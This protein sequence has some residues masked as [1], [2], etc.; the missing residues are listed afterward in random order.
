[1]SLSDYFGSMFGGGDPSNA[2][3][4]YSAP[5]EQPKW[6]QIL[7]TL[8]AT[9]QDTGAGINGQPGTAVAGL[10][11]HRKTLADNANYQKMLQGMMGQQFNPISSTPMVTPDNPAGSQSRQDNYNAPMEQFTGPLGAALGQKQAS[12]MFPLLQGMDPQSG[13]KAMAAMATADDPSYGT[14]PKYDAQGNAYVLDKGGNVKMLS[15][16]K[17]P[18]AMEVGPDGTAYDKSA[19]GPG[20]HIGEKK[21]LM[22]GGMISYDNGTTWKPIPGYTAQQAAIAEGRRTPPT[23][24]PG[25]PVKIP[26]PWGG[27]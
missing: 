25:D 27:Y 9:L 19:L 13:T 14:D 4:S 10:Q 6:A 22:V 20:D 17:K 2:A 5:Q 15:G 12:V 16:I 3:S 23:A 24:K 7:A 8:G 1:M 26:G 18:P 11:A 21:P